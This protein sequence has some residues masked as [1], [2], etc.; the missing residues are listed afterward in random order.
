MNRKFPICLMLGALLTSILFSCNDED[1]SDELMVYSNSV[2]IS[3]FSLQENGN[4]MDNLDTVFF[5]I[6]LDRGLIYNADSL[7]M[8]VDV[9]NLKVNMTYAESASAEFHVTNGKWMRDTVFKY[10]SED[11]ID[12]TGD[13]KFK[14]LSMDMSNEKT[15]T[16]K[17]NVHQVEPDTLYWSRFARRDLPS[18]TAPKDQKTVQ[19]QDKLYCFIQDEKGYVM[20]V[21]SDIFANQ[22][23]KTR[24]ELPFT[25]LLQSFMAT[26]EALFILDSDKAL[27]TSTDGLT[28]TSCG[29][30]WY[31]IIGSYNN[32]LLGVIKEGDVYKHAQYPESEGFVSTEVPV[33]FPIEGVSQMVKLE[34]RWAVS[35]QKLMIG[36]VLA[37]GNYCKHTWGYDG[38]VWG[39]I[40]R[41]EATL[42]QLKGITLIPYYCTYL[43]SETLNSFSEPLLLAM[44][45]ELSDGTRV[46][47]VSMSIDNGLTW[48]VANECLQLPEYI[49]PFSFAQA[50]VVD[51]T[52]TESRG[53]SDTWVEMQTKL[54][55]SMRISS[56][57]IKPITTWE[58]PYVYLI[59][60]VN[61]HG[62]L[63]NNIWQGV[64]NRL[65][66]KPL[67]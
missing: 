28:W 67:Y 39:I 23:E 34:S 27:Y 37:N 8:G 3:K 52:F 17:V 54:P 22:W 50:F 25:P 13:V 14:I 38:S 45:G 20:S 58:C 9:S 5:T 31:S 57:A 48:T 41:V 43:D 65:T 59:G 35:D 40:S 6:D 49:E 63:Y 26:D 47:V 32:T 53:M 10:N 60:G 56:R 19:L 66:F 61:E 21:T 44:G 18:F 29:L 4:V 15:Y 62:I 12:F 46:D 64:I 51:K 24:V 55:A 42:G 7:P 33:D 11:S 30:S 1:N 16:I 36:G 2:V